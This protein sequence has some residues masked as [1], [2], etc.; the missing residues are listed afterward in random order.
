MQRSVLLA[1]WLCCALGASGQ[2]WPLFADET[3]LELVLRADLAAVQADRNANPT[4]HPALLSFVSSTGDTIHQR[5]EIKARGRFRRDPTVCG[6]PPLRF[7]FPNPKSLPTPFTGQNKLKLVTHCADETYIFREYYIYK[8]Y[9]LLSDRSFRVRLAHIQYIDS[10]GTYPTET[11][12]GFFIE[13][14]EQMAARYGDTPIADDVPM[15]PG[16]VDQARLTLVHLFNYMIANRDFDVQV[17]QNV[18]IITHGEDLP[19][20]VPYDFDWAGIVDA[21]YTKYTDPS[22]PAYYQRQRF[23]PICRTAAEFEAAFAVFRA[24]QDAIFDLYKNSPYLDKDYIKETL[25]YL[26][27]FYRTIDN[28]AK[29]KEKFLDACNP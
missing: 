21:S 2:A 4:E 8:M 3:P 12:Y 14:E 25:G 9:S 1:V 11:R 27:D 24:Q 16:D 29:V 6:F 23:K 5:L 7:D 22:K 28:Q 20:V 10:S 17:R 19:I 15:Q 13:P 18:K 26:R